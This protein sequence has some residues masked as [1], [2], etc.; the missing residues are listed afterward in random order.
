MEQAIEGRKRHSFDYRILLEDGSIRFVYSVT[1]PFIND[2]GRLELIGTV[3]DITERK[4]IEDNLRAAQSELAR[5]TRL[6][7]MGELLAS[8]AHEIKQPLASIVTNA[9]TGVRWLDREPLERDKVRKTLLAA[10][11]AGNRAAEVVDSIRAMAKKAEPE[12]VKLDVK[13]LI[14]GIL[15]L[16][17]AELQRNDV[18]VRLNPDGYRKEIYGDRVQLQQVFLNL[19]LNG[20]E[21]MSSVT[22][23][24]RTLEISGELGE[25]SYLTIKIEDT[26]TGLDPKMTNRIFES[27]HTTKPQ[28]LGMGLSICRSIIEAHGGRMWA[29]PRVPYGATFCFTLSTGQQI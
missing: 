17:R 8:I 19:I 26:G 22:D 20:I 2:A 16:V 14:E 4:T 1:R 5:T 11:T 28:G 25:Q 18:T 29:Q 6:T 27:F 13:P 3:M 12:F 15:E 10:M 23:R 9:E 21:A 7:A 24:A